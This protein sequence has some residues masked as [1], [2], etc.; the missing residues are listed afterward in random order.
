MI[1]GKQLATLLIVAIAPLAVLAQDYSDPLEEYFNEVERNSDLARMLAEED[2]WVA[3]PEQAIIA[4]VMEREAF[5]ESERLRRSGATT[6]KFNKSLQGIPIPQT[7][8]SYVEIMNVPVKMP[9]RPDSGDWYF[10]RE[11]PPEEVQRRR[12]QESGL[13][14]TQYAQMLDG[15]AEGLGRTGIALNQG[16]ADSG[17]GWILDSKD[18]Q[19]AR[20]LGGLRRSEDGDL[21]SA[22]EMAVIGCDKLMQL[23]EQGSD[24]PALNAA[25]YGVSSQGVAPATHMAAMGCLPRM[26][27]AAMRQVDTPESREAVAAALERML[28]A[29]AEEATVAGIETVD[30]QKTVRIQMD[31][32]NIAQAMDDGSEFLINGMSVWIDPKHAKQRKMR[33]DGTMTQDG[34][35]KPFYIE[36]ERGDYRRVGNSY[37]YEP[38]LEIMRGGGFLDEQQQAEI[39][40]AM[41]QLDEFDKQVAAMPPDQRA[42]MERM[43]GSQIDALRRMVSGGAFEISFVTQSIEINPGYYQPFVSEAMAQMAGGMSGGSAGSGGFSGSVSPLDSGDNTVLVRMAQRDLATLGYEPGPATGELNKPTVVAISR[44]ETDRGLAVTGQ[45]TPQ[46]VGRLQADVE[47]L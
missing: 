34:Q 10:M 14:P 26:A 30:G 8:E 12:M 25:L 41:K 37:L 28:A 47:M 20:N 7:A 27:A 40:E 22:P 11:I 39:A 42:M 36:Q 5:L 6:I 43:M 3:Y 17:F 16:I 21:M 31:N 24:N 44:Y 38:H 13:S 46:L 19:N 23:G 2:G 9:G 33:F 32:L 45:V 18:Q 1:K 29:F 4:A 15:M 35:T